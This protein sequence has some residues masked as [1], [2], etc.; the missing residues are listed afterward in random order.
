MPDD[1]EAQEAP[2]PLTAEE[3]AFLR[4]F[5]RAVI[6]VPRVLEADLLRQQ[7]VSLSEYNALM[8]LSEAPDRRL[9]MS[10]LASA[11]AL[12]LSGMTRVVN[13]LE[14]EGWVQRV[15][16]SSDGRGWEATLTDTGLDRLR[17]AWPSHLASVRRHVID[18]V[19]ALDLP[20]FTTALQR[21][22]ADTPCAEEQPKCPTPPA[23]QPD[24]T[25][26]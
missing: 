13:R 15:R 16:A 4:A 21:F 7:G 5:G 3:E 18:H 9:R 24:S 17:Q 12:S 6:T 20:A 10:D 8:N 22:A 14:R 23:C 26:Q 25:T 1:P 2:Q 11:S 19:R